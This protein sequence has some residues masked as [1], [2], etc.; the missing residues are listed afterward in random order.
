[1]DLGTIYFTNQSYGIVTYPIA[2][3]PS[4]QDVSDV[5]R[6]IPLNQITQDNRFFRCIFYR[7]KPGVC[8]NGLVRDLV[9]YCYTHFSFKKYPPLKMHL[10]WL[11]KLKNLVLRRKKV[12]QRT[13]N[14]EM[15]YWYL[16]RLHASFEEELK[17]LD[18]LKVDGHDLLTFIIANPD[19][20][21][22][23]VDR[24]F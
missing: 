5:V 24:G 10:S 17:H 11:E 9:R 16:F 23:I 18:P 21:E 19:K 14:G 4:V 22:R 20:F 3:I 15:L 8:S 7:V 6:I 1:M 13:P 12:Q 2:S